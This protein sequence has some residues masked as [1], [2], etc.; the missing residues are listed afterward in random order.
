MVDFLSTFFDAG[1]DT[2]LKKQLVF[3]PSILAAAGPAISI[4]LMRSHG[5]GLTECLCIQSASGLC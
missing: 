5:D 1:N 3:S 4:Q 2:L